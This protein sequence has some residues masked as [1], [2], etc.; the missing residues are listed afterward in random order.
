MS[1]DQD[2]LNRAFLFLPQAEEVIIQKLHAEF[3]PGLNRRVDAERLVFANQVGD[4]GI[5]DENLV[6]RDASPADFR[7]QRLGD[8][9]DDRRG[10]LRADLILQVA[11]EGVDH[12]VDGPLGTVGVQRGEHDVAGLGGRNGGFNGFQIAHFA[13]Q[14]HVRILPESAADGFGEAGDIHADFALVDGRFLVVMEELDRI[15]N[16]DDVVIH[17]LVDVVHQSGQRGALAGAGGPGDQKQAAGAEH[18]LGHHVRQ[19]QLRGGEHGVGNLTQHHRDMAALLE[20]GDAEASQ[21]A[22]SEAEVGTSLFLQLAL[23][24]LGGDALHQGDGVVRLEG[25]GLQLPQAA[26][27][28]ENGRLSDDDMNIAG[29]LLHAGLQEFINENRGH[30]RSFQAAPDSAGQCRLDG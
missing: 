24:P 13:D 23:A 15:F 12:A 2:V 22:E 5:D 9:A 16:R 18:Q 21:V 19:S 14:D 3:S 10:K 29:P 8:N 27:E 30:R 17:I 25:L 26:V 7:Q 4:A 28:A 20:D 1:L 6:G 11:G